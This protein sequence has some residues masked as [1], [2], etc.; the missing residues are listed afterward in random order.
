MV[1]SAEPDPNQK[2]SRPVWPLWVWGLQ[3]LP[4]I[5]LLV[6]ALWRISLLD[7]R[8][9]DI[10]TLVALGI[11]SIWFLG[12]L[13]GLALPQGRA[14][15]KKRWRDW[16][17]SAVMLLVCVT[18]LDVA[19]TILGIVPTHEWQK[20]RSV[21]YAFGRLTKNRLVPQDI[22]VD[23]G[24]DIHINRHGY[25]GPEFDVT[26]TQDSVRIVFAGGSQVFDYAGGGWPAMVGDELRQRGHSVDV[27]N[28]GVAG[29]D[30]VDSLVKLVADVWTLSPDIIFL[31]NTWNDIKYFYRLGPLSPYR[32]LPPAEPVSW[33]KDWRL[34]PQGL[35]RLLMASSIY[36]FFRVAI[37]DFLITGEGRRTGKRERSFQTNSLSIDQPGPRQFALN[38]RLIYE[39]AQH[40]GAELVVC[41]QARLEAG[42]GTT[43]M[44][45][46]EY[47]RRNVGI[48][49]S[50][51]ERA[52]RIADEIIDTLAVETGVEV[53]DMHAGLQSKAEF[54]YDGVHFNPKGSRAV[55][56]I[57]ADAL[58]DNLDRLGQKNHQKS[59]DGG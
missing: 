20:A 54:F 2:R 44:P 15:L 39:L 6:F 25:R 22:I 42:A 33:N 56:I 38:L 31:C 28:V 19:L 23:N 35:D 4:A 27:L 37:I 51:L 18:I 47:V 12:I 46:E 36:R 48:S 55:S 57:I 1:P 43:G 34:Y 5:F 17:L 14:W 58:E 40:I 29:H 24:K 32:N 50:Q 7:G 21:K 59:I 26:K 45:V 10:K 52:Y 30:S 41:R 9:A 3:L 8:P 11:A 49:L 13:L 16:C 53:V